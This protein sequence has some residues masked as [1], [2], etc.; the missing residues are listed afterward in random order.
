M[1]VVVV[2]VM[3]LIVLTVLVVK[4]VGMGDVV[5]DVLVVGGV[6]RRG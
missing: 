1:V 2:G 5:G 4:R 3:D 6:G